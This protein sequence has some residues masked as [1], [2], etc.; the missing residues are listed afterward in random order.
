M[1]TCECVRVSADAMKSNGYRAH[2]LKALIS[3]P[4]MGSENQTQSSRRSVSAHLSRK[5]Q[6]GKF[7]PDPCTDSKAS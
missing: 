5:P 6:S 3:S 7:L 2:E 4:E 1:C